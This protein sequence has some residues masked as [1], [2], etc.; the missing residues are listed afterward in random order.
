MDFPALSLFW[1]FS[2]AWS[3]LLLRRLSALW[4]RLRL[5]SLLG[6]RLFSFLLRLRLWLRLRLLLREWEPDLRRHRHRGHT[7][8]HTA[9][10]DR[11]LEGSVGAL[12]HCTMRGGHWPRTAFCT[13]T[14]VPS[15]KTWVT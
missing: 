5:L 13:P 11:R 15:R 2:S 9:R 10:E 6:L 3:L 4:L 14:A 8:P 1:I 12:P 7:R